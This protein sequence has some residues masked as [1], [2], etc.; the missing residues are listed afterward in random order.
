MAA[1]G[2]WVHRDKSSHITTIKV[3]LSDSDL[4]DSGH[5][6]SMDKAV[7]SREAIKTPGIDHSNPTPPSPSLGGV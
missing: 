7:G 4:V 2:V 6:V 3:E 1:K 5:F